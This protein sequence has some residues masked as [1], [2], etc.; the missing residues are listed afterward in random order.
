MAIVKGKKNKSSQNDEQFISMALAMS[1]GA[2][3]GAIAL[4]HLH[5]VIFSY[6]LSC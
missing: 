4:L 5:L 6:A 3:I 2:A 1:L